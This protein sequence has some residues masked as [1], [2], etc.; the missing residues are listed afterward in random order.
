MGP[1]P[2]GQSE[3]VGYNKAFGA[4]AGLATA[5]NV[6]GKTDDDLPWRKGEAEFYRQCDREGVATGV[7]MSISKIR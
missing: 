4:F 2:A 5:E 1:V 3:G 7:P 6:M